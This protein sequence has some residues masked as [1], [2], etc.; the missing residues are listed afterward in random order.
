ML[1]SQGAVL[2]LVVVAL[3]ALYWASRPKGQPGPGAVEV[4]GNAQFSSAQSGS[5]PMQAEPAA[6]Q[7]RQLSLGERARIRMDGRDRFGPA[8]AQMHEDMRERGEQSTMVWMAGQDGVV[9][10][11]APVT[12]ETGGDHTGRLLGFLP[13][14]VAK[15]HG[16]YV[17]QL[18]SARGADRRVKL[19]AGYGVEF[20]QQ[21]EGFRG[22]WPLLR[23][24]QSLHGK[25]GLQAQVEGVAHCAAED[26][27]ARHIG[28]AQYLDQ[29]Q[30]CGQHVSQHMLRKGYLDSH[31]ASRHPVLTRATDA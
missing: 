10:D 11:F 26:G 15:S 17:Q 21:P 5:A 7:D 14:S 1:G 12:G 4:D 29:S 2:G 31:R 9:G 23:G 24:R 20:T 19:H 16:R 3:A 6:A 27:F 22:I 25:H 30:P 8:V 13:D 18:R 28:R